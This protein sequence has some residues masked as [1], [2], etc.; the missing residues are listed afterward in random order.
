MENYFLAEAE[1]EIFQKIH[2]KGWNLYCSPDSIE[3]SVEEIIQG[4]PATRL[5][6]N[7]RYAYLPLIADACNPEAVMNALERFA[8]T[9]DRQMAT[10]AIGGI[11]FPWTGFIP[12]QVDVKVVT[13]CGHFISYQ[14]FVESLDSIALFRM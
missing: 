8:L 12:R 9:R 13:D 5:R 14:E 7:D 10:I 3:K 1:Q 11:E 4:G 2:D 6:I